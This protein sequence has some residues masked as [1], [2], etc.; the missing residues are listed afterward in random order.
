MIPLLNDFR[1]EEHPESSGWYNL[2]FNLWS[3]DYVSLA[4]YA[5]NGQSCGLL[6]VPILLT[7]HADFAFDIEYVPSRF[8][9]SLSKSEYNRG[10]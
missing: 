9:D 7:C 5:A 1:T 3:M 4:V 6:R 8:V 2:D 10:N